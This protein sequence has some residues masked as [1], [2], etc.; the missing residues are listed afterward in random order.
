[1]DPSSPLLPPLPL[2]AASAPAP[3]S[4][5]H[6]ELSLPLCIGIVVISFFAEC[7]Y[8]LVSFGPAITFHIG[9][10]LLHYVG[11]TRGTVVDVVGALI[12]PE[13]AMGLVQ[14]G[15]LFQGASAQ[16]YLVGGSFL[17]GGLLVGL[18]LLQ[19]IG[20]TVWLKRG[21]GMALLVFAIDRARALIT[22][23]R[24]VGFPGPA[25]GVVPDM[26]KP[27]ALVSVV[28]CFTASGF[29]GGL[30][31]VMGPPLMLFVAL[32]EKNL[33]MQT[34]R[35]TGACIRLTLASVR[36]VFWV[37]VGSV[38]L[39]DRRL[40]RVIAASVA[41]ALCG[42]TLG[43]LA[44][45]HL[46]PAHWRG[47][48]VCILFAA[49]LLLATSD[50]K[51]PLPL[52]DMAVFFILLAPPV[53]LL[54]RRAVRLARGREPWRPT[55][56]KRLSDHSSPQRPDTAAE[57]G[58]APASMKLPASVSVAGRL[59]CADSACSSNGAELC[60]AAC[61]HSCRNER[62]NSIVGLLARTTETD[63]V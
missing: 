41:A 12:F 26:R 59:C 58:L 50:V 30:T 13:F 10:H 27:S 32:H 18:A 57:A 61:P 3:P 44:N 38:D 35:S 1:M 48:I 21:I 43:N 63:T 23:S 20:D 29:V 34:W 33:S 45:R 5:P 40:R 24:G 31:A 17:V 2:A 22:R 9:F 46:D 60:G 47:I 19:R 54:G 7:L 16:L 55:S 52:E 53:A 62:G 39:E 56:R 37:H 4:G 51:E 6:D 28:L 25:L 49:A 36:L 15:L 8:G 11:L 14:T 42:L